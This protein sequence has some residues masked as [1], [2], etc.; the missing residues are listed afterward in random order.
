MNKR[1]ILLLF[2]I[3]IL[4]AI[5]FYLY[6]GKSGIRFV[7][8]MGTGINIGNTLDATGI[9]ERR[10]GASVEYYETYWNNP[11]ITKKLFKAIK[12]EGFRTV[13]IPVTWDEHMDESYQVDDLWMDRVVQVVEEALDEGL[14]VILDSH[15]ET[16]LVPTPESEENTKRILCIVWRQIGERFEPYSDYL[17]F[18]GMNE[19]RNIGSDKEWSG[20]TK[21]EREVVNRLNQAFVDTV[22]ETGGNN[23]SRY[24]ILA[25]YGNNYNEAAL[26]SFDVPKDKNIIVGIHAYIPYGFALQDN[27]TNHFNQE[28]E[29]NTDKIKQVMHNL[30]KIFIRKNIPVMI[31][32]FSCLDKGNLSQRVEWTRFY[33]TEAKKNGISYVWWDNGVKSNL[34]D[35]R[36]YDSKY[37]Q[38]VDALL[39][40]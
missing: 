12:Q 8:K 30:N 1:D 20:G 40:R 16:W 28:K 37:P 3:L 6:Q 21:E 25:P 33:T 24:L 29:E 27:G 14:Y 36:E 31:T 26:L 5:G 15:H 23:K 11:Q 17:L 10:E 2:L 7:K 34:I 19:P 18:E 4:G 9:R 13:R 39:S 35:R 38:I 32:E 22:R